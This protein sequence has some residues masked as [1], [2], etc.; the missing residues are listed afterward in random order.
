[1]SAHIND[2][3][4]LFPDAVRVRVCLREH[5]IVDCADAIRLEERGYPPR[6]YLPSAAIPAR[7]LV[8][9]ATRTHCPY[10]GD[11]A[12]FHILFDG[13]RLEDAAWSYPQPLPEMAA[14]A[15]RIVFDHPRLR[16]HLE[17][18]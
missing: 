8:E 16:L 12:Y 15:G 14:I 2:R 18:C 1:M 6:H 13:E 3:I 5:I 7:S 9:S 4:A 17:N 10:K 11:A